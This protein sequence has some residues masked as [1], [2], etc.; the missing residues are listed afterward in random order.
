MTN[1]AILVL[2]FC[3]AA[4]FSA[5]T[6]S[7]T[8]TGL[9]TNSQYDQQYRNSTTTQKSTYDQKK[10]EEQKTDSADPVMQ[11]ALETGGVYPGEDDYAHAI[12]DNPQG[13]KNLQYVWTAT[14]GTLKE[15][16]ES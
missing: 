6:S 14:D 5:C 10:A 4:A 8:S 9:Q 12:V 13:R 15:V 11:V 3:C 1:R 2:L 7:S 16:P